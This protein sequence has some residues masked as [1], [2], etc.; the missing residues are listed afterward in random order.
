[1]K[2]QAFTPHQKGPTDPREL[3]AFLDTFFAEQ[4]EKLHVPGAVLVLVKDGEIFFAKGYGYTDPEKKTPVIPD[5]T[6]FRMGSVSKLFTATAVLQLYEQGQLNLN[7][8]VNEY[9]KHLQ[10]E[11]N[12]PE[13]VT[14][15]SLLTHTSGLEQ[16]GIGTA[17]QKKSELMPLREYLASG[18]LCRAMP[19]EEVIIYSSPGMALAG[20]LVEVISGVPFAQYIEENIFQPLD[21]RRSSFQQPLPSHLRADLAVGYRYENGTYNPYTSEYLSAITP[22]GDFYSTAT[23]IAHF[24]IA[25]L[26]DGRYGN[27]RILNEAT[28]QDMHQ[29][30]FTHHPR[31]RGRTYGFS[32]WFENNQRAIFH[33]G[34]A[35]GINSRLFLL[36]D[37][38]LGFFVGWNSDELQ[39]KFELTSQF[40][41][42]YYPVQ[43]KPTPPQ[44]PADFHNRASRFTGSY[45]SYE[46]SSKT[47]AKLSTLFEQVR[48]RD[49]GD[50]TLTIG[51]N[52]YAE[53]E[54]L[55]FQQVDGANCVAFREDDSDHITHLLFGTG[56]YKKLPWYETTVFQLGLIGFFVLAFLSA[57][58]IS[59]L[60]LIGLQPLLIPRLPQLLASLIGALDLVFLIGL[61]LAVFQMERW[62]FVY[63]IPPV[64]ISLLVIPLLTI[65][66]TV[67]LTIFGALA[68]RTEY[69]S[70]YGRL[71]YSLITLA[72]LTFVP[73]LR[74]WNLLGLRFRVRARHKNSESLRI[75]EKR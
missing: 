21:M 61:A 44:P 13:P 52:R 29:Q 74:Y 33:D 26:Q 64:L 17:V 27:S 35:P 60:P 15:A 54:P 59:F 40:L 1:M 55:L 38:N 53:V 20:Y 62:E 11:E 42:H 58:I 57:C 3:E 68:W 71:Y 37:Q 39:L 28:A 31:L 47:I 24:M 56:A 23:D 43:E 49:S 67:G 70:V 65:S 25:H 69:W 10:L 36:P 12:Y 16:R 2:R 46:F 5:K 30:H 9:L 14:V 6:I 41:D 48:V 22:A 19:S 32:E 18:V 34:A 75:G 73:F 51:T 8:D 45:R 72:T 66:L 50:G 4:M 63:G 7:D